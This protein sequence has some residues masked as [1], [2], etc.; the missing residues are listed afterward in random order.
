MTPAGDGAL[1]RAETVFSPQPPHQNRMDMYK[2]KIY[3][4]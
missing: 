2:L 3:M 4:I 1:R